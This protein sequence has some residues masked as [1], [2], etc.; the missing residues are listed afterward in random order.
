MDAASAAA[1]RVARGAGQVLAG[2][3]GRLAAV[4][5]APQGIADGAGGHAV[6]IEAARRVPT[7][8]RKYAPSVRAPAARCGVPWSIDAYTSQP[9]AG[10]GRHAARPAADR[11][12]VR[13]RGRPGDGPKGRL[14]KR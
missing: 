7:Y 12:G 5:R 3:A 8:L 10:R 4:G 2:S 1:D 9:A 11:G 6:R 14:G 13:G